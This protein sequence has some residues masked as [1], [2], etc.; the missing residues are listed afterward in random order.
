M[1]AVQKHKVESH[2]LTGTETAVS[3]SFYKFET[4]QLLPT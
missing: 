3:S 1:G 2:P 4:R